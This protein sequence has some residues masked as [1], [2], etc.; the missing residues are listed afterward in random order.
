MQ[1]TMANA[2]F[3]LQAVRKLDIEANHQ[4]QQQQRQQGGQAQK[5]KRNPMEDLKREIMIMKKMKHPNIVMLKE[6]CDQVLVWA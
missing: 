2:V 4:K 6:V 3:V 1:T 5:P